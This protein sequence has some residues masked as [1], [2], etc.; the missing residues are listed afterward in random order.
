MSN[1]CVIGWD[2]G[3]AHLKAA[4]L[5]ADGRLSGVWQKHCPLWRGLE[6][7]DNA[8]H[9]VLA[10]LSTTPAR[11][12]VTM[13]GEMTDLFE[14]RANG[15]HTLVNHLCDQL[16]GADRV[17]FYAGADG[18]MNAGTTRLRPQTVASA[19]WHATAA[20][21]AACLD[22]AL[23]VDIGSTT[24]DLILVRHGEVASASGSDSDRLTAGELVYSG[25][26][27]TPLMALADSAPLKGRWTPLMAEHFATTAD[28]YRVLGWLPEAADLYESADG[29]AKTAA[30][31]RV[32]LARMVGRDADEMP[33]AAWDELAAWFVDAQLDKIARAAR[34]LLS[35]GLLP[36]S[37][38]VV[39]AGAGAFLVE[40][41]AARLDRGV[42]NFSSLL[43]A[44]EYAGADGH[45]ASWCAPAVAVGWLLRKEMR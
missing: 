36:A 16:G 4:R 23:L 14:N 27:R 44:E 34:Q 39:A 31:S 32:R 28:V 29:G 20:M 9:S 24:C 41:L 21:V 40:R 35:R 17:R 10:E 7:L 15:V 43:K 13:T 2:V 37:A 26:V 42:L 30:A 12:A 18:W 3:G 6:H 45:N 11:H 1:E 25:V 33:D 8:L 38:P 19:N 22:D 5:E